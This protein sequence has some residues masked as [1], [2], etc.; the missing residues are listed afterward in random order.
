MQTID[1]LSLK[2]IIFLLR[3]TNINVCR[4]QNHYHKYLISWCTYSSSLVELAEYFVCARV[5]FLYPWWQ[6]LPPWTSTDFLLVDL[7][8]GSLVV[9]LLQTLLQLSR[10]T[11][12]AQLTDWLQ[13]E[14]E[15]LCPGRKRW[16]QNKSLQAITFCFLDK[17]WSFTKLIQQKRNHLL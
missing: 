12:V 2:D 10:E 14:L 5:V 4:Y 16:K 3:P 9:G 15:K 8:L 1:S 7:L 17:T 13:V 11:V 6:E